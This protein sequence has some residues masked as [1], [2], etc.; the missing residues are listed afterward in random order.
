MEVRGRSQSM[1]PQARGLAQHGGGL[2]RVTQQD[3]LRDGQAMPPAA[4]PDGPYRLTRSG[5]GQMIVIVHK[6][7]I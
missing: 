4:C 7:L 5:A 1:R 6:Q 3:L 2:R